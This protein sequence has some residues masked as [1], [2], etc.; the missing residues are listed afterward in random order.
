MLPTCVLVRRAQ[1]HG[2]TVLALLD[3]LGEMYGKE[4]PLC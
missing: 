3:V 4:V 2:T 1:R